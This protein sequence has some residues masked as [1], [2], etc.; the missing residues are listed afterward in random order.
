MAF[1]CTFEPQSLT[2]IYNWLVAQQALGEWEE[3]EAYR[4]SGKT[5]VE[6]YGSRHERDVDYLVIPYHALWVLSKHERRF[7]DG[8]SALEGVWLDTLIHE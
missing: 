3:L 2:R 4:L 7:A 5:L 1:T 6:L 8:L